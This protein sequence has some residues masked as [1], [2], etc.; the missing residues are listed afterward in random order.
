MINYYQLMSLKSMEFEFENHM[1]ECVAMVKYFAKAPH[2]SIWKK[3]ARVKGYTSIKPGTA[4][5]T[6]NSNG[7]FKGHAAIYISQTATAINVYD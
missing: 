7:K 1:H 6:F 3:G 5:A 2:T 4:I